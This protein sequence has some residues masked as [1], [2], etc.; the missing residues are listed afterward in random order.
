MASVA[1]KWLQVPCGGP[2]RATVCEREPVG[3]RA[4]TCAGGYCFTLPTTAGQK[5]YLVS[6]LPGSLAQSV[7]SCSLLDGGSLVMLDS[8]EEREQ[9]AHEVL[10]HDD[11]IVQQDVWIGLV[12]DAGTWT[13]EDGVP[14]GKSARPVPWGNAQPGAAAGVRAFMRLA[15]TAYDTQLVY[16]DDGDASPR[17]FACQRRP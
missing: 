10:I 5:S 2:R 8:A 11:S 17:V 15:A 13:W 7:E 4:T 1:G 6:F 12:Q 9:L 14:L 3:T 16:A